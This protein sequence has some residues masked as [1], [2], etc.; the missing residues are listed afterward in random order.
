MKSIAVDNL[1]QDN[2]SNE[3]N[4]TDDIVIENM[5]HVQV[6]HYRILNSTV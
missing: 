1:L 2:Q 3:Q 5:L 6:Q 4:F